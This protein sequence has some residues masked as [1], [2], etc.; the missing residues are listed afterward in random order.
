MAYLILVRHGESIWNAKGLWTGF[1][2]ISLSE[3]GKA[4]AKKAG[5]AIFDIPIHIAFTSDLKR[6][7]ETLEEILDVLSI[8]HLPV[9]ESPNLKERDYGDFTGKNKWEI[10]KEY[11]KEQ[12]LKWRR[13]WNEPI[14]GGETLKDVYERVVPYYK[15]HILPKLLAGKNVLISAH[16]NSLRALIKYL[17]DIS[18]EKISEIEMEVGD[19]YVYEINN[20]GEVVHKEIRV[21]N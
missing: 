6:S 10:E 9:Y 15:E 3:K 11:G 16:G 2:D 8:K 13:G 20:S 4:Q 5:L 12:F 21:A 14:P 18:D 1:T 17:E 7:K 19:V